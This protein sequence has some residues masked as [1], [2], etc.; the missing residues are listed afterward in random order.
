MI[1]KSNI[2]HI[3]NGIGFCDFSNI[4]LKK[5]KMYGILYL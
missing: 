4:W 5:I 2:V 1:A 3:E